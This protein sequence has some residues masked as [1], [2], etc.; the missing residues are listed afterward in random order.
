[1][2]EQKQLNQLRVDIQNSVVALTQARAR[3]QAA[4]KE[5]ELQEQTLDAEQK[6]YA[7][8]AST[9]FF[10]IQYQRD[11][12]QAQSNEVAALNSYAKAKTDLYRVTGE[13][14]QVNNIEITEAMDGKI[15]RAP[16]VLP[17]ER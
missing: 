17:P 7:L 1:L 9:V 5:R 8:G 13:T 4:V 10:V 2:N 14:L 12:A 6:K 11:L 15:S 3:H 16:S